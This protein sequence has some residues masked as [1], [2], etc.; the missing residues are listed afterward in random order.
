M[1]D[2]LHVTDF[3][4]HVDK[5]IAFINFDYEDERFMRAVALAAP[6]FARIMRLFRRDGPPLIMKFS[7]D[8]QQ[9][10]FFRF[11]LPS[12]Y[13]RIV[14]PHVGMFFPFVASDKALESAATSGDK[15]VRWVRSYSSS[16]FES[17]LMNA[18]SA[19]YS[20]AAACRMAQR[21]TQVMFSILY[22]PII[23]IG[24]SVCSYA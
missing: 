7:H 8:D 22:R 10:A 2:P 6:R 23:C 24:T 11:E 16:H 17:E 15:P 1:S 19:F 3:I 18:L 13:P 4:D 14:R 21:M 9:H 5:Y 20:E 12:D